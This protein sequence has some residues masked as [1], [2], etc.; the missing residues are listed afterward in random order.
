MISLDS[1]VPLVLL[2]LIQE[3]LDY[4]Q[5]YREGPYEQYGCILLLLLIDCEVAAKQCTS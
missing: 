5:A 3:H 2:K 4:I 1:G